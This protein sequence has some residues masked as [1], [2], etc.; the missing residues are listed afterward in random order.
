MGE[1]FGMAGS[2]ASSAISAN[3][4]KDATKMQLDALNNQRQAVYNELNP[5]SVQG[6][7]TSADT[8]RAK[9]RL[10]LQGIIDPQLLNQRYAAESA[11]GNDLGTLGQNSNAVA[12]QATS[13]ALAG[14]P[15]LKAARDK[16]I[17]AAMRELNAGATLPPDVQNEIVRT[18]LEKTGQMS[19]QATAQGFGGQVL[20]K[21]LGSAGINLQFQR[22]Q[23]ASNLIGQA[24]NLETQRQAILGTL[25]PNLATTQLN[26]LKGKQS[27][28]QQSDSLVPQ[29]GLGGTDIT[30]LLLA[31]VGSTN[32]LAQSAANAASQGAIG[33]AQ[34]WNQGLGAATGYGAALLPS[35]RSGW[36]SLFGSS[37]SSGG[38]GGSS[39]DYNTALDALGL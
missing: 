32:Q 28:L 3:A 34:A 24:Q 5:E 7:A 4:M 2:I 16:L 36:N 26:T 35:A 12:G 27:V 15:G 8:E 11:I 19:G 18:G 20:R 9:N 23:A 21:M 10:A 30:N 31:R 33:Q 14:V 39:F 25:F 29:A 22:Q 1:I 13:E 17:D 37:G 38:G 6:Q